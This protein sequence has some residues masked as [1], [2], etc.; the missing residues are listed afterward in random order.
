MCACCAEDE[1]SVLTID[2]IA[3][4]GREHRLALGGRKF[5]G[6]KFYMW[7]KKS[8]FPSGYQVLCW[9]CNIGKYRNGGVCPHVRLLQNT[10]VE[11]TRPPKGVGS[12]DKVAVNR[13]EDTGTAI[14][15]LPFTT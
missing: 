4:N 5:S 13:A 10:A 15:L 14:A 8:G 9:N 1:P 3:N 11:R 12:S 2:H 6:Q 7:L